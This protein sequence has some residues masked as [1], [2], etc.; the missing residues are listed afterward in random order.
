M[1]KF[2][3][4]IIV[5]LLKALRDAYVKTY[6]L[7]KSQDY[8][9]VYAI[10]AA[11]QQDALSIGTVIEEAEKNAEEVIAELEAYCENIYQLGSNLEDDNY[12]FDSIFKTIGKRLD[13]IEDFIQNKIKVSYEIVFLPYS[14]SMWDSL[15]S[16]WEAASQD[17]NCNCYIIPIPYYERAADS[18]SAVMK[19]EGTL[20]PEYVPITS[21]ENYNFEERKPDIIYIHNPYDQYNR[22]TSVHPAY[23]S[24]ELK[25]YTQLLVYIP[26]FVTGGSVPKSFGQLPV[27]NYMDKMVVQSDKLMDFYKE[28]V[29]SE[30]IVALGSP[31]VDRIYSVNNGKKQIPKEWISLIQNKK[32]IFYNTSLSGLLKYREKALEK[33]ENV[34]SCFSNREKEILLWRP[35]PLSKATLCA[36]MPQMYQSYCELEKKFI[37]DNIGILDTTSDV[38]LSVAI[39]DAYIGEESSSIVHLFGVIGKPI[40]LLDMDICENK[41]GARENLVG[42]MDACAVNGELWFVHCHYNALCKLDINTGKTE[43]LNRVP[44]ELPYGERLYHDV[45]KIDSKLYFTPNRAKELIE[46]DL[47]KNHFKKIPFKNADPNMT[48][49]FTRMVRYKYD[50]YLLPTNYPALVRYNVKDGTFKYYSN[51]IR[52]IKEY[53]D[54]ENKSSAAFM[55]AIYVEEDLLLMASAQANVV[56]E[57]NM[58]T[59]KLQIYKVGQEG[60]S[61]Y[62]MEYDGNDYWL[63]PHES[64]AIV[65][66]NR[67]T[68]YTAEYTDYPKGFSGGK[69]A[70]TNIIYCG[71]YMLAF[72]KKA[73]MIVKIDVETGIMTEFK[74]S[75]PY[76]EGERKKEY[77]SWPN[78]YYFVKKLD[79]THILAMT[80]YDSSLLI[81]DTKTQA[82]S[83]KKCVIE[84]RKVELKFREYGDNLPYACRENEYV[85]IEDFLNGIEDK[86]V[87]R[88]EEQKKAYVSVVKNMDGTCGRKIHDYMMEQL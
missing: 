57:F 34:F 19:Y 84:N 75:L 66:W 51:I 46:Y 11:C 31:K 18:D 13:Y 44:K 83:L 7:I 3:K 47:R 49:Q 17:P 74:L 50:L 53:A 22:V 45:L 67:K 88:P 58:N 59:E 42:C 27:Y 36:M 32:V 41:D 35:H 56:I 4:E 23:Y 64:K 73:N 9:E 8:P 26:Y 10:L 55:S 79:D 6:L 20:M 48:S 81:I 12:D 80:A 29:P 62:N 16:I 76:K 78:N 61:Y 70:F 65:R 52:E 63:V 71:E 72:P 28:S 54:I 68:G 21:Y 25:K 2:K 87:H 69:N 82:C 5:N 1:R 30:K 37:S 24:F 39:S 43:I 85:A 15:E 14:A 77:Y 40:F 86:R 60:N 33:M 38:T